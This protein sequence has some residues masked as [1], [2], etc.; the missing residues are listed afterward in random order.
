[1]LL[2]VLL[3]LL[4]LLLLHLLLMIAA[5]HLVLPS[6]FGTCPS[7]LM[8]QCANIHLVAAFEQAGADPPKSSLP[9]STNGILSFYIS[10][11]R[12]HDILHFP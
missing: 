9:I 8:L 5:I 10:D 12:S 11:I 1:M 3:L 2:L 6:K 4:L 7:C